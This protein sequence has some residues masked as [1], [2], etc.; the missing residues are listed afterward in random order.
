MA[1]D[2]GIEPLQMSVGV[3]TYLLTSAIFI[4]IAGWLA[5]RFGAVRIF[6]LAIVLFTVASAASGLAGNLGERATRVTSEAKELS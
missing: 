3:T 4:P 6:L 1:Q 5:D 2:F